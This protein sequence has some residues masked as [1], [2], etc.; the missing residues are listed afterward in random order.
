VR[1]RALALAALSGAATLALGACTREQDRELASGHVVVRDGQGAVVHELRATRWGYLL[2]PEGVRIRVE[3][4]SID[5]GA[6]RWEGGRLL[7]GPGTPG[8]LSGA[9]SGEERLRLERAPGRILLLS[10]QRVPLGQLVEREGRIWAYDAGGT[11][12]GTAGAEGD[13]VILSD[14]EGARRGYVLGFSPIAAASL[15]IGGGLSDLERLVL[16]LAIDHG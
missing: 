1:R 12:L 14:R 16:A 5:A 8:V 4:R 7:A 10:A 3:G 11:P 2:R 13:R 6:V 15:L 9:G